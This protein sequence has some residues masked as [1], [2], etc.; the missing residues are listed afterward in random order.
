M[1]SVVVPPGRTPEYVAAMTTH[2]AEYLSPVVA[3]LGQTGHLED[4]GPIGREL[5]AHRVREVTPR[6]ASLRII[7]P[8]TFPGMVA[9]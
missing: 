1:T 9:W 3:L 5:A 6:E 2:R 4:C 7:L 8:E